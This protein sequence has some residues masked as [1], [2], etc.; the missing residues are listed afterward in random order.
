MSSHGLG[1]QKEVTRLIKIS[2]CVRVSSASA[3]AAALTPAPLSTG[4]ATTTSARASAVLVSRSARSLTKKSS[5][6]SSTWTALKLVYRKTII[7]YLT[8]LSSS[9][10][11]SPKAKIFS[12]NNSRKRSLKNSVSLLLASSMRTK[13]STAL[14][15][16]A[17]TV[18][19]A[20]VCQI[21]LVRRF[22]T[23][24]NYFAMVNRLPVT[25]S[26]SRYF[27]IS[28]K[29]TLPL[30]SRAKKSFPQQF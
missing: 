19:R 13:V 15:S 26:L 1:S 18:N 8:A 16:V 11:T 23:Y 6:S 28:K 25:M 27:N 3:T 7:G 9:T 21:C 12:G 10:I 14:R 22:K 30:T 4:S 2:A 24:F 20:Q 29:S 17:S 5:A